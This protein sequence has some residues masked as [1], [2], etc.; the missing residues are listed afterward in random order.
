MVIVTMSWYALISGAMSCFVLYLYLVVE[1]IFW[2]RGCCRSDCSVALDH[3]PSHIR[4][5]CWESVQ[6]AVHICCIK[7]H[8]L[9]LL[10]S[11]SSWE[12]TVSCV[13]L[14][15]ALMGANSGFVHA[16][17]QCPWESCCLHCLH[18]IIFSFRAAV[19][20]HILAW[21]RLCPSQSQMT[22]VRLAAAQKDLLGSRRVLL[23]V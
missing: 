7:W 21:F 9:V 22:S 23:C 17:I 11:F 1:A 4:R 12:A 14:A 18:S 2:L 8:C 6:L 5:R 20:L 15:L 10:L 13:N 3:V 16:S 19:P